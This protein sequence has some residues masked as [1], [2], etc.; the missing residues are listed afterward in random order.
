MAMPNVVRRSTSSTSV[1]ASAVV[2]V[3]SNCSVWILSEPT[4]ITVVIHSGVGTARGRPPSTNWS[5]TFCTTMLTPNDVNS[6]VVGGAL[7]T[8][9]KAMRSVAIAANTA[10][11]MPPANITGA[12]RDVYD[13]ASMANP[14]MVTS[15]P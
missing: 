11:A 7:R 15:S 14:V 3:V 10:A 8:G 2:P 13:N 5:N 9:R 6:S 12:G 1:S 4:V